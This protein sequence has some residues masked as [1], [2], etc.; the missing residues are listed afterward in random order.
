MPAVSW[1]TELAA[2]K[3]VGPYRQRSLLTQR[4]GNTSLKV[5]GTLWI[6]ASGTW[7]AHAMERD[8]ISCRSRWRR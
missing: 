3:P 2:L 8:I 1:Q 4:A 7:L 6:K 5:D